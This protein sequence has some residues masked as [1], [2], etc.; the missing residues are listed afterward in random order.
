MDHFTRA[1]NR[2]QDKGMISARTDSTPS[3]RF[4]TGHR[5]ERVCRSKRASL[6]KPSVRKRIDRRDRISDES[7]RHRLFVVK[8]GY[9]QDEKQDLHKKTLS[10]IAR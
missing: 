10:K 8:K 2:Y 1:R 7:Q 5:G 4:F 6:A 3:V 9:L